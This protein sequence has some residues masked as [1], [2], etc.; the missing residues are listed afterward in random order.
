MTYHIVIADGID[1]EAYEALKE[2]KF[3]SVSEKK[4]E[5]AEMLQ[6]MQN[7]EALVIRSRTQV[8]QELLASAP[9]LK[10]VIRAGVGTDNIDKK[11]C[12]ERGIKV[13]NTPGGNNNSAAEHAIALMFTLLR[14]TAWAHASTTQGKWEKPLFAGNELTGKTLGIV[15]FGNIGQLVARRLQGFEPR[16]L[17]YDPFVKESELS[18]AHKR[19]NL[20]DLFAESDVVSIHLPLLEATRNII[21]QELLEK[22]SPHALLVN[23]ARGGIVD[24]TALY[25]ALKN[26]TLAAAAFDVF[27]QEPFSSELPLL[28]LDNFIATP[29]IG[30]STA[31][32][33]KRVGALV[34]QALESF[35]L[36]DNHLF[37][38]QA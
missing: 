23:C 17:F 36:E 22:L 7:A 21:N 11:L 15:G 12:A 6:E 16:V 24:E 3:F 9:K 33:Q 31:E 8:N 19:E 10:Y 25:H 26:K 27:A 5:A 20:E 38:V 1:A 28:Q 2:N 34:L 4:L 29:H 37:E 32:A 13:S 30:A 14:K 18:Y 35:F